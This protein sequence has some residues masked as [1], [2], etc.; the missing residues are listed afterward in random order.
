MTQAPIAH[1]ASQL[2]NRSDEPCP[3]PEKY[4]LTLRKSFWP[5]SRLV[6]KK[7]GF[8]TAAAAALLAASATVSKSA[9]IMPA[10]PPA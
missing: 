7:P 8:H 3:L 4:K 1:H 6:S 9:A 2:P 5:S 10:I